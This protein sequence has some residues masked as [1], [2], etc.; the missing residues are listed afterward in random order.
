MGST[1]T[2]MGGDAWKVLLGLFLAFGGM[3]L[4]AMKTVIIERAV[5]P[6]RSSRPWQAQYPVLTPTQTLVLQTPMVV[7]VSF[8]CALADPAGLK[9]PIIVLT[10]LLERPMLALGLIVNF[11]AAMV[12]QVLG[13][14]IIRML[15]ATSMQL[16]GKFNI[17]IVMALSAAYTGE[18]IP[19][20]EWAGALV[21]LFAAN[22]FTKAMKKHG[23]PSVEEVE[24]MHSKEGHAV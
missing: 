17:F 5:R 18:H 21:I 14:V 22:M 16:A 19:M 7:A 9:E 3:V 6:S 8:L 1:L 2:S 20:D 23:S 15:G 11:A 12:L 10:G 24:A 13:L 4:R